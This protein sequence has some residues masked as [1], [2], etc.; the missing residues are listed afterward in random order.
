MPRSSMRDNVQPVGSLFS[1]VDADVL[2]LL[3][4]QQILAAFIDQ[5]LSVPQQLALILDE[6]V[7][8]RSVSLFIGDGEKDHVTVERDLLTLQHHHDDELRQTLIF[9]V[10]RATSPDVSIAYL[11][12]KR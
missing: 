5:K 11:A 7:C 3:I 2:D 10:L 6:P 12:A 8:S 4:L 9:H 1:H